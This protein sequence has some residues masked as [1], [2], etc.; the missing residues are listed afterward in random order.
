MQNKSDLIYIK[1]KSILYFFVILLALVSV[2]P[3][4]A[5]YLG[6]N[7]TVIEWTSVCKVVLYECKYVASKGDWRYRRVDDWACSDESKPWQA[8]SSQPSSQGCFASTTGDTY[9]E[10]EETLQE[11]TNTYPPAIIN[12]TLQNCTLNNG[13]CTTSPELS[14][15]G[16][17][18]VS[19]YNILA[20]EGSLNGQTFA[21]SKST[22][23]VPLS[24]GDNSFTFWA[25][26]S[27]GDSSEMGTFT[28]KVDTI[29]PIVGL[30]VSGSNGTN[31]VECVAFCEW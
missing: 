12:N 3:V 5:D 30:D 4:L 19:G 26:S 17:E 13:W 11:V 29:L 20:I 1:R 22:C 10:R 27:W 7:R 2:T 8:Y 24:E 31:G 23:N 25:L 21:C 15:N 28:A 16:T 9:W 6:P 14:I 18:P